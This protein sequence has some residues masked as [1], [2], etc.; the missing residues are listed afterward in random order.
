MQNI[1]MILSL[2]YWEGIQLA[3]YHIK[4]RKKKRDIYT[5]CSHQIPNANAMILKSPI[6]FPLIFLFIHPLLK[7]TPTVSAYHFPLPQPIALK[8]RKI[9]P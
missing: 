2:Y 9:G 5:S 6:F 7:K 1:F 3:I 8:M 4:E